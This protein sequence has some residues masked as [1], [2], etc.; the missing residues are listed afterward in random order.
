M[1]SRSWWRIEAVVVLLIALLSCAENAR[2]GDDLGP[3]HA[4]V[5]AGPDRDGLQY[6]A[7]DGFVAEVAGPYV[8]L[9]GLT[10]LMTPTDPDLGEPLPHVR[11]TVRDMTQAPLAETE[12]D[13]AG[14]FILAVPVPDGGTD[15]YVELVK[16]GL[17]TVRQFD[18]RLDEHW[19]TMRLRMLDASLYSIPRQIL[20][21]DERMGY[22]QGSVYDR[23]SEVPRAGVR[24]ESS[25]GRVAYL[26]DGIPI[27]KT[28]L[29]QTQSHGVFFVANC[30]P[31]P[32][33]LTLFAGDEV[34]AT[35]TV[36]TWPH[37]VL[38]QVGV[39]VPN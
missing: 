37:S 10:R 14:A 21:Q 31:G 38:T 4:G 5:D 33:T 8:I 17:P 18:R 1:L 27:P 26:S 16:E 9:A 15:G 12:S 6:P 34:V 39:P 28:D 30:P 25:A 35:R 36:L 24:V 22:V 20:G 2:P 23:K 32:V 13:D 11:I 29:A 7:V 3:F 19:T